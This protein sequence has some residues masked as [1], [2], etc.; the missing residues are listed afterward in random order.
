VFLGPGTGGGRPQ[1]PKRYFSSGKIA[2]RG[3]RLRTR[4]PGAFPLVIYNMGRGRATS[5]TE[6]PFSLRRQTAAA[7]GYLVLGRAARTENP[8]EPPFQRRH[9]RD[10]GRV[11]SLACRRKLT[12]HSRRGIREGRLQGGIHRGR[13]DSGWSFGG[14]VRV[15]EASRSSRYQS[16]CRS[17][18]W[19]IRWGRPRCRSVER[20]GGEK[21]SS[22]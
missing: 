4:A 9:W 19:R 17:S 22:I 1:E 11:T 10:R 13:R 2:N 15:C 5:E 18:W 16:G 12:K 21:S 7:S 20:G 6:C 14:I 8:K 3:L